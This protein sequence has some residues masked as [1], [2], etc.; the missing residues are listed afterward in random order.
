M[1]GINS[2]FG[3]DIAPEVWVARYERLV[4][5]RASIPVDGHLDFLELT[6]PHSAS[7]VEAAIEFWPDCV[8]GCLGVAQNA[9]SSFTEKSKTDLGI[10]RRRGG[11]GRV[12]TDSKD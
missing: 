2:R 1:D 5:E 8:S 7:G 11:S 10:S 4:I 12:F 9:R 6:C 3:N